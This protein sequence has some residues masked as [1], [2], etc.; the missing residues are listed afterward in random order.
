MIGM[1]LRSIGHGAIIGSVMGLL[2]SVFVGLGFVLGGSAPSERYGISMPALVFAYMIGGFSGGVIAG[3]L[4]FLTRRWIGTMLV[5]FLSA[6]P[7]FLLMH[8]YDHGLAGWEHIDGVLVPSLIIGAPG[9]LIMRY[10]IRHVDPFGPL[11]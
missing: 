5:G 11:E 3:I 1:E 6:L 7:F 4:S 8:I 10:I 9:G 2:V